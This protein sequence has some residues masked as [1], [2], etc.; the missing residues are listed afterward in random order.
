MA[1]KICLLG[2]VLLLSYTAAFADGGG[3]VFYGQQVTQYPFFENYDITNNTMGLI[4]YGG[5]GYGIDE[6]E[7]IKGGFGMTIYDPTWQ[8]GIVGGFG[9]VIA[10]LRIL[11]LPI[12]IS[13]ISYTG[14]GGLYSGKH[15]ETPN[16]G[17]FAISEEINLEIGVPIFKWFMPVIYAGYQIQG[18]VL[19]GRLFESFLSY[20][21]V[22]GVK[23]TWG[24]F[25]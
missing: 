17:F 1:K 5:F 19:P 20:T 9:G 16:S 10:G 4:Y 6:E 21:P 8:S 18:N 12:N 24:I 23:M 7:I 15:K 2:I 22:L 11:K 3:G 13:V 25:Y 14:F